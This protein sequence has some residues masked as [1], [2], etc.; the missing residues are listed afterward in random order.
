MNQAVTHKAISEAILKEVADLNPDA[1]AMDVY[2]TDDYHELP[3]KVIAILKAN[4][5]T[6]E[7]LP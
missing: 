2:L 4:G 3:D 6:V 1:E 5:Y 7:P